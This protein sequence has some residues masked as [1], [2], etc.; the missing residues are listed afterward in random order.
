MVH[1]QGESQVSWHKHLR[2]VGVRGYPGHLLGNWPVWQIS[3]GPVPLGTA[4]RD[5]IRYTSP[6]KTPPKNYQWTLVLLTSCLMSGVETKHVKKW[7]VRPTKLLC[8]EV[9]LLKCMFRQ[10]RVGYKCMIFCWRR[11]FW[12]MDLHTEGRREWILSPVP[13]PDIC[14]RSLLYR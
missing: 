8:W 9:C 5:W 4:A 3:R 1:A 2:T 12:Y 13:A 7:R 11:F 6:S 10:Q 14:Q